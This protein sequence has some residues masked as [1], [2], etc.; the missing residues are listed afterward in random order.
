MRQ[1]GG[2][3]ATEASSCAQIL[4]SEA[5]QQEAMGGNGRQQR[6]VPRAQILVLHQRRQDPIKLSVI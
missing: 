2:R 1:Q 6:P 5:K 3:E 4:A